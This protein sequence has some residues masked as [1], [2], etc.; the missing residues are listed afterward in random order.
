M[1][2]VRSP[3]FRTR[4]SSNFEPHVIKQPK[5]DIE[6]SLFALKRALT[7]RGKN[8]CCANAIGKAL[9]CTK[10]ER[11]DSVQERCCAS[12]NR[13]KSSVIKFRN[14]MGG[15]IHLLRHR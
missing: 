10:K 8:V 7:F 4:I 5:N 11:L 6:R 3:H 1:Y 13:E 12:S 14:R 2:L 9:K 15:E